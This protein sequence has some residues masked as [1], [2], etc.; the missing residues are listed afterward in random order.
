[1]QIS[2]ESKAQIDQRRKE[3]RELKAVARTEKEA[4]ASGQL[5][6]FEKSIWPEVFVPD[7]EDTKNLTKEQKRKMGQEFQAWVESGESCLELSDKAK[8]IMLD[9]PF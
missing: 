4:K 8:K 1:M 6:I 2:F 9:M 3:V 5:T 7:N